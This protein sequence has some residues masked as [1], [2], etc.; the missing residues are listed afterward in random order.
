M[1]K[2]DE[3]AADRSLNETYERVK[4]SGKA[5]GRTEDE[6]KQE[7]ANTVH[8]ERRDERTP[9]KKGPAR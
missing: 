2:Q 3:P 7:A 8:R 1:G 5:E 4:R 6:A 9:D